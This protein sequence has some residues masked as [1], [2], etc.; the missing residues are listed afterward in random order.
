MTMASW[1]GTLSALL[2]LYDGVP[3]RFLS[4]TVSNAKSIDRIR[5]CVVLMIAGLRISALQ[6]PPTGFLPKPAAI[7]LPPGTTPLSVL[8]RRP[9]TP[10]PYYPM[11]PTPPYPLPP[12]SR[13][14]P[15]GPFQWH[16]PCQPHL[17]FRFPVHRLYRS[18]HSMYPPCPFRPSSVLQT[19]VGPGLLIPSAFCTPPAINYPPYPPSTW[20]TWRHVCGAPDHR[21]SLSYLRSSKRWRIDPPLPRGGSQSSLLLTPNAMLNK[22]LPYRWVQTPYGSCDVIVIF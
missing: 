17:P 3:G 15:T 2:A 8:I 14:G 1:Y 11:P 22:H 6:Q 16:A 5:S 9:P 21:Y 12:S 20:H 10:H 18:R 7:L 4:Q 19:S 13:P